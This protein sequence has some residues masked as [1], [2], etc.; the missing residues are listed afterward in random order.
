MKLAGFIVTTL[1]LLSYNEVIKL[2]ILEREAIASENLS[3][4]LIYG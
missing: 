1:G 2:S 3:S 4:S